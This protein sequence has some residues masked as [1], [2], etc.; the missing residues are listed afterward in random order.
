M[1]T[2]I[3]F[4]AGYLVGA[5]EGRDGVKRLRDSW[6]SI[7]NSP[8]VRRLAGEGLTLAR[9]SLGQVTSRALGGNVGDLT[10]VLARKAAGAI[11]RRGSRA[12]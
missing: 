7:K 3:G 11:T 1:E 2:I 12:A 4:V 5:S 8:E 10:D 9:A 6:Q